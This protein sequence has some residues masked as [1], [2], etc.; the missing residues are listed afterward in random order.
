MRKQQKQGWLKRLFIW[1]V[2]PFFII[3]D[4][5]KAIVPK[6]VEAEALK[7]FKGLTPSQRWHTVKKGDWTTER[8]AKERT[9]SCRMAY[10]LLFCSWMIFAG[11]GF[12]FK[13]MTWFQVVGALAY[14]IA[15]FLFFA[16]KSM[17]V[18]AIDN[19]KIITLKDWLLMPSV[20]I[21]VN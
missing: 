2:S 18:Y 19:R 1:I 4:A 11:T 3:G 7:A 12:A 20:W 10:A 6:E 5:W 17:A 16:N 14:G 8:V 13:Y 9:S 21:P 15:A